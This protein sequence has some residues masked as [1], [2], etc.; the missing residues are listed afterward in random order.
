M[1][2]NN[3]STGIQ[4]GGHFTQYIAMMKC[5]ITT[6]EVHPLSFSLLYSKIHG[7]INS[8]ISL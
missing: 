1:T 4:V 3:I 7:I 8:L 6:H 5:I 2:K